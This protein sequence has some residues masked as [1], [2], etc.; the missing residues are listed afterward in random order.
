MQQFGVEMLASE[1]RENDEL[2]N[3]MA[4]CMQDVRATF[5]EL[6]K[7]ETSTIAGQTDEPSVP[8]MVKSNDEIADDFKTLILDFTQLMANA[9]S[10]VDIDDIRAITTTGDEP[11]SD[12]VRVMCD[13][14]KQLIDSSNSVVEC[15]FGDAV[16]SENSDTK[17]GK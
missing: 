7:S 15:V 9:F 17:I 3:E 5:K 4:K 6:N 2:S 16:N 12:T 8:V 13:D 14:F 10:K 1:I 11:S